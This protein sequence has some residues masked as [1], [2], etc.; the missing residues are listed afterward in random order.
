MG[1]PNPWKIG[2]G[3]GAIL[4]GIYLVFNQKNSIGIIIG[5]AVI[6]FGVGLIASN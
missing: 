1:K 5:L 2:I 4:L 6:A 3:T